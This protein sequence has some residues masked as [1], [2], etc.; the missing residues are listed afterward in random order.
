MGR[1]VA[2]ACT[3][4]SPPFLQGAWQCQ[5]TMHSNLFACQNSTIVTQKQ[6]EQSYIQ[7]NSKG[8]ASV[9][10]SASRGSASL[11]GISHG[12]RRECSR[13]HPLPGHA[14]RSNR[15]GRTVQEF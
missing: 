6:S 1:E 15:S 14:G 4:T 12:Q 5:G 13:D 10:H 8:G 9:E 7:A 11:A 3:R 2:G